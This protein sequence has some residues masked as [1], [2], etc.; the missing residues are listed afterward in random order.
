MSTLS[1][2]FSCPARLSTL[3]YARPPL[4]AGLVI[5]FND[6][7]LGNPD[8]VHRFYVLTCRVYPLPIGAWDATIAPKPS[9]VPR[10]HDHLLAFGLHSALSA[11]YTPISPER[12]LE[13]PA[14]APTQPPTRRFLVVVRSAIIELVSS[15]KCRAKVTS[16]GL[17]KLFKKKASRAG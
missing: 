6:L 4:P 13:N 12:P 17:A 8:R 1:T 16:R 5:D 10:P 14:S 11:T 7:E 9:D 3:T 15:L 2:S